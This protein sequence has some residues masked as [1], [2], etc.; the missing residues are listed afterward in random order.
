MFLVVI[1]SSRAV[2][3]AGSRFLDGARDR[4][5]RILPCLIYLAG[6]GLIF[7]GAISG[8]PDPLIAGMAVISFEILYVVVRE[9][10]RIKAGESSRG[11]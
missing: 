2:T 4:L 10:R 9:D 11:G 3:S 1:F 5:R 7:G 6:L 8:T